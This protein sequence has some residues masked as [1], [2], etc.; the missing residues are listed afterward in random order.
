[1]KTSVNGILLPM[2]L[3]VPSD[4]ETLHPSDEQTA[5]YG[6]HFLCSKSLLSD[7]RFSVK[8]AQP[9]NPV[10]R[11]EGG[12]KPAPIYVPSVGPSFFYRYEIGVFNGTN[13]TGY[14]RMTMFTS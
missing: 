14:P 11:G 9:T 12:R 10:G 7:E 2:Q 1:M 4:D 3:S 13:G 8:S 5:P 6:V